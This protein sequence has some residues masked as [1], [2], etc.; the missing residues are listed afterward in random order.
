[1]GNKI[2]KVSVII[3]NYNYGRYIREAIASVQVQ[4]LEDIEII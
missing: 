1:M 3:P 4:T 2:P